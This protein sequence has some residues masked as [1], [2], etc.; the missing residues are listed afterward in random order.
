MWSRCVHRPQ[1]RTSIWPD[2]SASKRLNASCS[3]ACCSA[4]SPFF[5]A[6]ILVVGSSDVLENGQG[7]KRALLCMHIPPPRPPPRDAHARAHAP[8]EKG[9]IVP[10]KYYRG[11]DGGQKASSQAQ[12]QSVVQLVWISDR[13]RRW[14][15]IE[16]ACENL[17]MAS[18]REVRPQRSLQTRH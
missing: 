8:S 1:A 9:N 10:P 13:W 12:L 17:F 5:L 7:L 14:D 6:T 3:S 18:I 4:E 16:S 15:P 2:L 11:T